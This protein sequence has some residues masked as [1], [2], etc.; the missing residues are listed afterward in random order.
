MR[1]VALPDATLDGAARREAALIRANPSFLRE[2]WRDRH[3]RLYAVRRPRPLASGPLRALALTRTTVTLRARAAGSGIVRVRPSPYWA[4]VEGSG[5]V[6]RDGGLAAGD[7][8]GP[9]TLRLAIRF[10]PRRVVQR[11]ARCT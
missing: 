1:W 4:V 11:G 8:G 3:W 6:A 9:G 2:V 10:A 7:A 5:C